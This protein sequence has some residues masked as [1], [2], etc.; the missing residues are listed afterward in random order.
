MMKAALNFDMKQ[1]SSPDLK[2]LR[3][4]SSF[5]SAVALEET[6]VTLKVQLENKKVAKQFSDVD[7]LN[8]KSFN[9]Y[10][11]GQPLGS[12]SSPQMNI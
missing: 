6:P 8:A 4:Q 2:N 11:N 3:C 7:A 5:A 10:L 9:S 12:Q 1:M